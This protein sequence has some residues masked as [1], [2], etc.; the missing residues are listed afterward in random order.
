MGRFLPSLASQTVGCAYELIVVDNGS[1]DDTA[2]VVKELA[3]RSPRLRFLIEPRPGPGHARHAGALAARGRV[4]LFMDDDME[5]EPFLLAEHLR[6]HE[7]EPGVCVLGQVIS[8]PVRH[9]FARMMA[10][11][12][13]GPRMSLVGRT[14]SALDCWGGHLSLER[15]TYFS[16]GGFDPALASR[17]AEDLGLGLKLVE[18]GV[19]LRFAQ[20]AVAR[21]H[22]IA[23]FPGGLTRAFRTGRAIGYLSTVHPSFRFPGLRPSRC[24]AA[25]WLREFVCRLAV[26]PV[27]PFDRGEGRPGPLLSLLYSR[28]LNA[29]MRRGLAYEVVS[30]RREGRSAPAKSQDAVQNRPGDEPGA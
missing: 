30:R 9:P 27:Q 19:P 23:R 13:D 20:N 4:L 5:A 7:R 22:F 21:H 16:V 15:Q 12:Y 8:A 18:R 10:W 1:S 29:A 3:R 2:A 24:P 25:D 14:P 17:A 26:L 28:A 6:I 11:I